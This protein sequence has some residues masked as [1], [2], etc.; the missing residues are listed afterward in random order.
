MKSLN[1]K[2]ALFFY[3][4]AGLIVAFVAVV[5]K[6]IL[7]KYSFTYTFLFNAWPIQ[8]LNS[9]LFVIGI[10]FWL[11]RY[12]LF[13]KEDEAF[14]KVTLPE[15][16]ISRGEAGELIQ[17]MPQ[18]YQNTLT[19][20]RFREILQA[21]LWGEDIIRLNEELSRRDMGEVE[22]GHLVLNS[23]RNIIPVIGFLGTVVGLALAMVDF[24]EVTNV[25]ILRTALRGFSA[26][27]SVAFNT[28][29]LALAYTVLIILLASFL[30]QREEALVSKVDERARALVGK[31]RAE[32]TSQSAQPAGE[33]Q[34]LSQIFSEAIGRWREE[35]SAR[36]EE[37][38]GRLHSQNGELSNKIAEAIK[39][40]LH[41]PPKY[42]IVVQPLQ[43]RQDAE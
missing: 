14:Q 9:W 29:L 12:S 4:I 39:E 28:T 11:Q 42:Q 27:L 15:F 23:L 26:S 20:R 31:I 35:F 2:G 24:P 3:V 1:R 25:E 36:M 21:F 22:R 30:K 18:K 8:I 17:T 43:E 34:R 16:S 6:S 38:L 41:S 33:D 10:L 19:L 7:S 5:L 37:C 32:G 40:A 13:R